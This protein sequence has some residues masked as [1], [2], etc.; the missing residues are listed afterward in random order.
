LQYWDATILRP[1]TT[2]FHHASTQVKNRYTIGIPLLSCMW[3]VPQSIFP[4]QEAFN[5]AGVSNEER[6]LWHAE[7]M[8]EF[9]F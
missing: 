9:E 5:I 3:V 6:E 8:I 2:Q 1:C 7:V 4:A